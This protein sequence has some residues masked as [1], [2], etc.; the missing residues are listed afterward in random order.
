MTQPLRQKKITQPLSLSKKYN[1]DQDQP[2]PTTIKT[3]QDQQI[4]RP[5]K[6]NQD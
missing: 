4:Q 1:K 6:T 3:N 5:T 2:R